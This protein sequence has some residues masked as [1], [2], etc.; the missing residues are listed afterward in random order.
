MFPAKQKQSA[1]VRKSMRVLHD[2]VGADSDSKLLYLSAM[3]SNAARVVVK[4]PDYAPSFDQFFEAINP[5]TET[6]QGKLVRY[7]VYIR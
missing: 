6:L 5:P 3:Q 1:A 7:D 4:R 2:L